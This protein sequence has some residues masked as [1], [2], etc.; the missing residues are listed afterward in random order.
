MLGWI[1]TALVGLIAGA[2]A[3]LVMPGK[4][5][6]GFIMTM[7]LGLAGAL[8]MTLIGKAI[9][10]YEAGEGAGFIGSFLGAVI[11]LVIYR[12]YKKKAGKS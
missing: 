4:D 2:L 9:G 12:F 1:W 3:K 8:L 11:L 7:L 5:G 6:G 10:W